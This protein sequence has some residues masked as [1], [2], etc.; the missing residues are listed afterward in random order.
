MMSRW[1]K[2]TWNMVRWYAEHA[3]ISALLFIPRSEVVEGWVV[4][5]CFIHVEMAILSHW[6]KDDIKHGWQTQVF[7]FWFQ[8]A[9]AAT[10]SRGVTAGKK[11]MALQTQ[12]L[13][14][15]KE[16][17][18]IPFITHWEETSCRGHPCTQAN[19]PSFQNCAGRNPVTKQR[20][21][22]G[23]FMS[24]IHAIGVRKAEIISVMIV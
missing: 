10:Q 17:R 1:E 20:S 19:N 21:A 16:S 8:A 12:G 5:L 3:F 6:F 24:Y 15:W 4:L 11:N 22:L 2:G 9:T 14:R 23:F 7:R 18:A 13:L